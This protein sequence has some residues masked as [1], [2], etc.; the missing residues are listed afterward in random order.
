M[1]ALLTL[2]S[3]S[4]E[5]K[6]EQT[7]NSAIPVRIGEMRHVQEHELVSVSGTVASPDAPA[8]VSFLVSGKVV[9]VGPRE[10]EYVHKGQLLAAIDPTDYILSVQAVSAQVKQ[11]RIGL[12][13]LSQYFANPL[14]VVHAMQQRNVIVSS[15]HFEAERTKI[16]LRTTGLFTTEDQIRNVLVDVSRTGQPV[17]I[18]DFAEVERRYQDPTF[19]VRY[20]GD[21]P[22][23]SPIFPVRPP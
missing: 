22:F 5:K 2:S 19:V 20:D 6:A 14:S 16:P 11:A 9:Q 18:R 13:R 10:G 4:S 21:F 8:G 7:T 12:E 17:Y 15:G 1:V 23:R 3:C